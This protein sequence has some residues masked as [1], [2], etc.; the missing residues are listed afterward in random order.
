MQFQTQR[1]NGQMWIYDQLHLLQLRPFGTEYSIQN[2]VTEL[3][4]QLSTLVDYREQETHIFDEEFV[5]GEPSRNT[6]GDTPFD[7]DRE[8]EYS[9]FI[10]EDQNN[11]HNH[12][13][14]DDEEPFCT[15]DTKKDTAAETLFNNSSVNKM[16]RQLAK[17]FHPDLE[18]DETLKAV[19]HQQM[20]DLLKARDDHD[21]FTIFELYCSHFNT[22]LPSFDNLELTHLNKLLK[23]QLNHLKH[24]QKHTLFEN[25]LQGMIYERFYRKNND[26]ITLAFKKHKKALQQCMLDSQRTINELT[27]VKTLKPALNEK[28]QDLYSALGF[29]DELMFE[30][31]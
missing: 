18:Q 8:D 28:S 21:V 3:E 5:A 2:L 19:K 6:K 9:A 12:H 25:P 11:K 1:A 20:A 13:D 31:D 10:N 24:E 17:V 27:T 16:F 26:A 14:K 15:A 29:I 22:T 7:H 23:K 4:T 30:F